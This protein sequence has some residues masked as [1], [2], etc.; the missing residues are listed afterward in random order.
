MRTRLTLLA[1]AAALALPGS[2]LASNGITP[3]SPAAG[4][5]VPKGTRPTFRLRVHG[6]GTVW[7][8]VCRSPTRHRDGTICDRSNFGRAHRRHGSLF[9][10]TPRLF[11]FKAYWLQTP[12]TYY[13]QA[14]RLDCT[15]S[16]QDCRQEGAVTRF[17]IG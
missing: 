3:L 8:R 6:K 11:K 2:A 10:Y 15:T 7:V 13:W 17:E 4:A 5:T 9:T 16:L 14:Y 12:G 1:L